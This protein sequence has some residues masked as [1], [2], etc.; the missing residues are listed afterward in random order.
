[1]SLNFEDILKAKLS[2]PHSDNTENAT[3]VFGAAPL[4]LHYTGPL[5][6]PQNPHFSLYKTAEI[7]QGAQRAAKAAEALKRKRQRILEEKRLLSPA[8]QEAFQVFEKYGAW[9]LE[10][11]TPKS[12]LK[13]EYRRISLEVHP[14]RTPLSADKAIAHLNFIE[15]QKAYKTLGQI[16]I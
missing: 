9:D 3:Y 7:E 11:S 6:A 12:R 1:M 4:E 14:D 5:P 10:L 15:L 13:K 8:L 16:L 2:L